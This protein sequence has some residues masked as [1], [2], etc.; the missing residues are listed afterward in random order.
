MAG[1]QLRMEAYKSFV[2]QVVA[3]KWEN[4]GDGLVYRA[5]VTSVNAAVKKV[6]VQFLD[7][8]NR[9]IFS[10]GTTPVHIKYQVQQ[11]FEKWTCRVVIHPKM[12][13]FS[14]VLVSDN[15]D[16]FL[17]TSAKVG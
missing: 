9:L 16:H 17:V 2:V 8:G 14:N 6:K 5:V 7:F 3:C 4:N 13:Q 12:V 1:L 11:M 15:L 10:E